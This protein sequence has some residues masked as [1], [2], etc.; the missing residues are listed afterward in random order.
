MF[1]WCSSL[2]SIDIGTFT[3]VLDASNMF[4]GCEKLEF[5]NN[6]SLGTGIGIHDILTN[7]PSLKEIKFSSG[8]EYLEQYEKLITNN[9]SRLFDAQIENAEIYSS[10]P[11]IRFKK[12]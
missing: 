2:A 5:V 8:T 9:E 12:N 4:Y 11:V 1:E 10:S 3:K 6:Y 7:C